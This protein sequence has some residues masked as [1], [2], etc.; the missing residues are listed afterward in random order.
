MYICRPFSLIRITNILFVI[1]VIICNFVIITYNYS[2]LGLVEIPRR[3]VTDG[4]R[5]VQTL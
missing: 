5:K 4:V 1:F 2:N 3:E